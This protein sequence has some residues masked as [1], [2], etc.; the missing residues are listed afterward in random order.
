MKKCRYWKIN[1]SPN[2]LH[3]V[4]K[5]GQLG[6]GMGTKMQKNDGVKHP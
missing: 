5:D 4:C 2:D 3:P 6:F 1:L